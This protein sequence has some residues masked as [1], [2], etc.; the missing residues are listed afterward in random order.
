VD[1]LFMC[2][3][4]AGVILIVL[5]LS[6][7][8]TAVKFIP[9]PVVIG[10]TNGIAVLIAS[11]QI[12]DFF[13][14]QIDKVPGEF[15]ARIE[16]LA[17]HFDTISITS[18]ALALSSLTAILLCTKFLKRIPGSIVGLLAGTL[19]VAVLQLPVET[20]GT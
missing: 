16:A 1:G 6:G 12:R 8:G 2:T 13:G 19:V 5:A 14:L 9:R 18:T 10:F 11:T 20:I 15:L 4:M 7:L 3:M 17:S